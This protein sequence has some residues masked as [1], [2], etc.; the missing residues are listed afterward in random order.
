MSADCGCCAPSRRPTPAADRQPAGLSA[1]AYRIG[2]FATFR[3]RSLDELVAHAGARRPHGARQRRLHHHAHRAVGGGR[4]RAHVLPG[5]QRQRGV[6]AHRDAARLGAAPG[7]ADRLPAAARVPRPPRSSPSR[8]KPARRALIPAGTRVQSVPG[9]G[10]QPQKFETLAPV[11]GGRAAQPA[12]ALRRRPALASPLAAA[13]T[14]RSRRR[15]PRPW[16]PRRAL[17]RRR[18]RHCSTRAPRS[19][20][21]PCAPSAC[22]DDRLIVRF[23]SADRGRAVRRRLRRRSTRRGTPTSSAARSICS[24]S[25]RPR[26]WLPPS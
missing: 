8:S 9:E 17:A 26:R 11:A 4:R 21:S 5:A 20:C 2:T 14:G 22:V 1:V 18:S 10:E 25:T 16:L 24:A 7:A 6:P 23:A 12:A 13:A 3:R 15:M 19:R